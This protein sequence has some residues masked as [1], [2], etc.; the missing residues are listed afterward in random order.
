MKNNSPILYGVPFSQPVR[1]VMWLMILQRL[2]FEMVLI[3]PGSAGRT[4]SRNPDFL[5][6]NPGGTI[7]CIEEPDTGFV[8]GEAHAIMCYLCRKHGWTGLYPEDHQQ[9]ARVDWYLHFHHRSLRY[10]SIGFVAPKI[11]KDIDLAD[12][13]LA[14]A[15]ANFTQALE[16]LEQ[17]WLNEGRYLVGDELTLADIA[18]YVEIGQ[19]RPGFT[20]VFDFGDYPRVQRWLETMSQVEG[21]DDV[22][23][24]LAE[25]GDIS[26]EAPSMDAI[27]N[28]N[29]RALQALE[30][31]LTELRQA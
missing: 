10:G 6:K 9:R 2:P 13:V 14:M 30:K 26:R 17:G 16:A 7:P 24:V 20:N 4:G 22:H 12:S 23:V 11:R 8:L 1:A 18:A 28:A 27:K 21:H 31:K 3:N 5:A 19:M 15:Q 29:K 25:L